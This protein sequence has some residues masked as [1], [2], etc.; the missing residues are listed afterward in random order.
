MPSIENGEEEPVDAVVDIEPQV[1]AGG[2][3]A[4]RAAGDGQSPSASSKLSSLRDRR[5]QSNQARQLEQAS[6]AG[7]QRVTGLLVKLP[8]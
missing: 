3:E 4:G 1:E 5:Q 6:P 2:G 8:G 7:S